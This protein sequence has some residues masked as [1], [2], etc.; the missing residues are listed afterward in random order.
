M[1]DAESP[2]SAA[3]CVGDVLITSQLTDRPS[4]ASDFGAENRALAALAL[5]IASNPDGVLQKCAELVLQLCQ[6]DSAGISLLEPGGSEAI[7]WHASAGAFAAHLGRTM[8]RE[9]CPCGTVIARDSVL[10]FNKA[11]RFFPALA[12]VEPPIS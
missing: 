9:A 7:R 4:R 8:T 5:E 6:A 12:G 11:E 10:L 3:V 1:S 2:G